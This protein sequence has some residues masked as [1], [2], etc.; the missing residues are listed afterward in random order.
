MNSKTTFDYFTQKAI[1]YEYVWIV[2]KVDRFVNEASPALAYL[3]AGSAMP[4]MFRDS[5]QI[6][7]WFPGS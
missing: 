6:K 4:H 3:L 7:K 5:Y 1:A 2:L